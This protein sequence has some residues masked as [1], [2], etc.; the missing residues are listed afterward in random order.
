MSPAP[1]QHSLDEN[2]QIGFQLR[3]GHLYPECL[4][5]SSLEGSETS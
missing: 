3:A 2:S 4:M 1:A 5:L